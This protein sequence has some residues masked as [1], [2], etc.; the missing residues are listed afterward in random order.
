MPML[1]KTPTPRRPDRRSIDLRNWVSHGTGS[2]ELGATDA[3]RNAAARADVLGKGLPYLVAVDGA[4][5]WVT[6]MP[7]GFARVRPIASRWRTLSMSIKGYIGAA[8]RPL[9]AELMSQC[10]AA[11]A[12]QMIAVIGDSG[13]IGS[14]GLYTAMGFEHIG[15]LRSTGWKFD[16]WLDTVFMQRALGLGA[17]TS[18]SGPALTR[19]GD[20]P[21]WPRLTGMVDA[22]RAALRRS[23]SCAAALPGGCCQNQAPEAATG[24][25]AKQG[26]TFRQQ[27]V[28][29]LI[30]YRRG[31]LRHVETG[32]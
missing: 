1:L 14:I 30:R 4:G 19:P 18:P 13:N 7:T 22:G 24:R 20:H 16:R 25:T 29:A 26:L 32:R 31:R 21:T 8:S 15:T 6:P 5:C 3:R 11:G 28:A 27:G 2:F 12:R 9:M 17:T 10:E 23:R